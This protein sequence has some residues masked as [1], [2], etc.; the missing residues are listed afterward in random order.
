MI[1]LQVRNTV[2]NPGTFLESR[3]RWPSCQLDAR[4]LKEV[5]FALYKFPGKVGKF[6]GKLMINKGKSGIL[7]GKIF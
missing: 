6:D 1:N 5:F 3:V 2:G 4:L 7:A